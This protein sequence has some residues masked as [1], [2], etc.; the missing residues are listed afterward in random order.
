M[1]GRGGHDKEPRADGVPGKPEQLYLFGA[2]RLGEFEKVANVQVG[3][4]VI[5]EYEDGTA[6]TRFID[7]L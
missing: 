3:I 1:R 6:E 4:A 7:L 2:D 5:F